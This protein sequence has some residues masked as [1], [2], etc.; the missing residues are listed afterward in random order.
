MPDSNLSHDPR[1]ERAVASRTNEYGIPFAA[2]PEQSDRLL[3]TLDPG[4]KVLW[5]GRTRHATPTERILLGLTPT[6]LVVSGRSAFDQFTLLPKQVRAYRVEGIVTHLALSGGTVPTSELAIDS[7]PRPLLEEFLNGVAV[8]PKSAAPSPVATATSPAVGSWQQAEEF[9]AW[10]MRSLGFDDARTTNAGRDAGVDVRAR[11]AVAQVKYQTSAI[12]RPA[13]QQLRGAAHEIPWALFYA[14]SGYSDLAVVYADQSRVAL[15]EYSDDGR[16]RAAN[17]GARYLLDA[18][19]KNTDPSVGSFDRATQAATQAQEALDT[20][21]DEFAAAVRA[22]L[23]KIPHV[24]KRRQSKALEHVDRDIALV[25]QVLASVD[26]T[27]MALEALLKQC[28]VIRAAT[29]R[30]KALRV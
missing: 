12:G 11:D 1:T 26:D 16:V 20:A 9:A 14:Q 3:R 22:A 5:I 27:P 15:F 6:R 7:I 2:D 23:S 13:V 18:Q 25:D 19:A 30:M 28:E 21:A 29:Q 8:A 17:V 10:H 4:E 24:S